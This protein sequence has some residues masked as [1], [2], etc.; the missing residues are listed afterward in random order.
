MI[1]LYIYVI[2]C[3]QMT[4]CKVPCTRLLTLDEALK[5][6]SW[7]VVFD[8]YRYTWK[9]YPKLQPLPPEQWASFRHRMTYLGRGFKR[10]KRAVV[11]GFPKIGVPP[12]H[13]FRWDYPYPFW[14]T[15]IL[16][17]PRIKDHSSIVQLDANCVLFVVFEDV[18]HGSGILY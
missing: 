6:P 1:S 10:P 12:K 17:H 9:A 16:G 15:P 8:V 13:P 3:I 4:R 14:S 11:S 7:H 18:H 2:L 5:S